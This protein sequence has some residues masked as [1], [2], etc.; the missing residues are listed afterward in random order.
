MMRSCRFRDWMLAVAFASI[1]FSLL[2]MPFSFGQEAKERATFKVAGSQ[3]F[4]LAFSPDSKTLAT[5]GLGILRR[6]D[7]GT[8]QL[9]D[10]ATGKERI[11]FIA[12]ERI[13]MCIRFSPNGQILA[14]GGGK[15]GSPRGEVKLWDPLTAKEKATL[16]NSAD[17]FQSLAFSPD[18][19]MLAGANMFDKHIRLWDLATGQQAFQLEIADPGIG[20]RIIFSPDG[21]TLAVGSHGSMTVHLFDMATRKE[22]T[23]LE[24][25]PGGVR[26]LAFSPDGKTLAWG[27]YLT[28]C[29]KDGAQGELKLFDIK[30][31]RER[32]KVMGHEDGVRS[33]AF[34]PD[35][36]LLASG[37]HDNLVKLWDVAAAREH[38]TLEGHETVVTCVAFS[39]DGKTLASG[40]SDG[41][42]K[43]WNVAVK[44]D[45]K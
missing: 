42:V 14:T 7:P 16:A 44:D 34:S 2:P 30:T 37:G 23:P 10:V 41:E 22:R 45:K 19:K 36:K 31:G 3:V 11:S 13:V 33:V 40:S 27:G 1:G 20:D 18:G 38:A 39:P 43:L 28:E 29:S 5:G 26:A 6:M 8:V 4:C 32:M 24:G 21:K 15:G 12:H 17:A 9:W 35:G 25:R